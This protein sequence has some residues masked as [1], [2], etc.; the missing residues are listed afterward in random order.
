MEN[1][2]SVWWTLRIGAAFAFLYPAIKAVF[3]PIAWLGYFPSL[4]RN[5]PAQLGF[6]IDSLVLLHGFGVIEVVLAVWILFGR[7]LRIP[8]TLMTLMLL[9]IV[10]FNLND[11]DIVFRDISI[12]AMTLA[13]A[14]SPK[15]VAIAQ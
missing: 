15:P 7:N 8:A 10:G 6:P 11:I 9:A 5:L 13:L 12:A 2:N 1:R 3:D 14:L 4:V